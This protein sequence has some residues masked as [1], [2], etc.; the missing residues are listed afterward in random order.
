MQFYFLSESSFLEKRIIFVIFFSVDRKIFLYNIFKIVYEIY[1]NLTSNHTE[2]EKLQFL[3][4]FG[5]STILPESSFWIRPLGATIT[6]MEVISW[7]LS[8]NWGEEP[9]KFMW[10]GWREKKNSRE[11]RRWQ[12]NEGGDGL[13]ATILW[14]EVIDK[15]SGWEKYA[16]LFFPTYY[17][18]YKIRSLDTVKYS[19]VLNTLYVF[20]HLIRGL[21]S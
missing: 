2:I 17:E 15:T 4:L 21:S 10:L 7:C 1:S 8:E 6:L 18:V 9:R 19:E 16:V 3:K 14:S 5:K 13:F 20:S 12:G 11:N